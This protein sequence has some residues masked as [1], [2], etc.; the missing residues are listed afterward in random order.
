MEDKYFSSKY[1]PKIE[2]KKRKKKMNCVIA[3]SITG[4]LI[5]GQRRRKKK[6]ETNL[7]NSYFENH[8]SLKWIIKLVKLISSS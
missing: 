3:S 2:K 7:N 4:Q 1:H 5:F 8:I 6:K